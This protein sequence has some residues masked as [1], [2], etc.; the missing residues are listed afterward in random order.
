MKNTL[1]F[2][3]QN[4]IPFLTANS[5][6]YH[7]AGNNPIKY[8]DPDGKDEG[9]VQNE[10]AVG[11]FGHAGIFVKTETGYSFFE[12]RGL[13][14]SE[15]KNNRIDEWTD[16]Q[17]LSYS[18]MTL[19][20]AS[21]KKGS[22]I[23][24]S[25]RNK[26]INSEAGVVQLNFPDRNTMLAFLKTYGS[27]DGFDS[28][29]MFETTSK[30]DAVIYKTAIDSGKNFGSYRVVGN[31]CGTWGYTTLTSKGTGVKPF[32]MFLYMY[33]K[34]A[35]NMSAYNAELMIRA[36]APN[37]IGEN[38]LKANPNAIRKILKAKDEE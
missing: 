22:N 5:H 24:V 6:L 13:S 33:R 20:P 11:I 9:Y 31:S 21:S 7:Y 37:N 29:I 34:Y 1:A 36:N 26:T 32:D 19:P 2:P 10:N 14:K 18:L 8:I 27:N 17:I 15:I 3:L 23:S 25:S 28:Y 12:V 30:Q 4:S 35:R 38:L 16:S